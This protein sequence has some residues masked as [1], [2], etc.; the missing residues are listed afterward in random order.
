MSAE[1]QRKQRAPKWGRKRVA[2]ISGYTN[3]RQFADELGVGLR[4]LRKWR[5]E[6]RGPPYVKFA[7]QIHYPD[8]ARAAW[9]KSREV[10][11]VRELLRGEAAA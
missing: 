4:T 7:R 2:H 8:E 6:G 3:E 10:Q 1:R 11:P 9:L 5:A